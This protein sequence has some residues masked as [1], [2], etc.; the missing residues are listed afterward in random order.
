MLK[1]EIRGRSYTSEFIEDPK[2]KWCPCKTYYRNSAGELI[3]V[4]AGWKGAT[5][6]HEILDLWDRSANRIPVQ[7]EG[8]IP[9]F[10]YV[11]ES[12]NRTEKRLL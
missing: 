8:Y 1:Y 7:G 2:D 3:I 9:R 11:D 5:E 6:D 10:N 12:G 4:A